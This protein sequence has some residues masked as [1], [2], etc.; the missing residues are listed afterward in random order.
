MPECLIYDIVV[1]MLASTVPLLTYPQFDV[2]QFSV[3]IW[4]QVILLL[5]YC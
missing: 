2:V 5:K 4:K 1:K 3:A